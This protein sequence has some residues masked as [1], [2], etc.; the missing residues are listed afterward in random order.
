MEEEVEAGSDPFSISRR[1]ALTYK[2]HMD[3][4]LLN[5]ARRIYFEGNLEEKRRK[6]HPSEPPIVFVN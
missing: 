3:Q 2:A 1:R 6:L 4:E 5:L